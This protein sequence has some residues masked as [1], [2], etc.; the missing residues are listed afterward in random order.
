M[1]SILIIF[2]SGTFDKSDNLTFIVLTII[3]L[4]CDLGMSLGKSLGK[5][6]EIHI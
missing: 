4:I 1:A 3:G 2:Y 6:L 5:D